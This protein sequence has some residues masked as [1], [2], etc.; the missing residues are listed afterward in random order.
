MGRTMMGTDSNLR[1]L[2]T[3]TTNCW[4]SN[5]QRVKRDVLGKSKKSNSKDHDDKIVPINTFTHRRSLIGRRRG[6]GIISLSSILRT[7]PAIIVAYCWTAR[8]LEM[9]Q[10][11]RSIANE[12]KN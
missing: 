1:A 4:R 10:C 7:P 5:R 9:Y 6:Y 11:S 8:G 12:C 2:R 3:M